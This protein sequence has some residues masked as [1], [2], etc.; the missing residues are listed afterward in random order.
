VADPHVIEDL[1]GFDRLTVALYRT[2]LGLSGLGVLGLSGLYLARALGVSIGR[3]GL[4]AALLGTTMA[5]ALSAACVHL[6]DKRIRWFIAGCAPL[7]L[8]LQAVGLALPSPFWLAWPVQVA[9]VGFALV[10]LSALA[11]KEWFC[12]RI[13]GLRLVPV[14]LGL[15]T[16]PVVL[17]WDLGV[18]VLWGPAGLLVVAL[19]VAKLRMPLTHDI[20]DRSRYQV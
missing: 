3:D 2:G 10:S 11:F 20:G 17:D 14:L 4:T 16:L 13:P 12:F 18:P 19:T 1:D 5:I 8:A 9:G 15:G 7:G 6:Y